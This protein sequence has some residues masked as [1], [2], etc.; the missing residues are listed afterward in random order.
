[1]NYEFD[2]V[3]AKVQGVVWTYL[4]WQSVSLLQWLHKSFLVT[5]NFKI[6]YAFVIGIIYALVTK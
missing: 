4:F 3:L 5:V 2:L 1:M 6:I